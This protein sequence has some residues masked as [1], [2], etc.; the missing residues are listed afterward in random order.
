[1][2]VINITVSQQTLNIGKS[3]IAANT[4]DFINVNGEFSPEW[5]DA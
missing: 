4:Y 1:M 2:N 3:L 5:K